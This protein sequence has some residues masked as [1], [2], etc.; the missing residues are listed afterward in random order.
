MYRAINKDTGEVLFEDASLTTVV[1]W[2][3]SFPSLAQN[4]ITIE[5]DEV[6]T[7]DFVVELARAISLI[8][9]NDS[10]KFVEQTNLVDFIK[11]MFEFWRELNEEEAPKILATIE[12]SSPIAT[13][14]APCGTAS[15]CSQET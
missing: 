15:L 2:V 3:K 5:D 1:D 4:F 14:S 8:V 10:V 7:P 12:A 9:K 13:Q 6:Y 11:V